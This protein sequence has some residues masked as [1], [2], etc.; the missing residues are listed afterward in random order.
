MGNICVEGA[1][2]PVVT[3]QKKIDGESVAEVKEIKIGKATV[4]K[5]KLADFLAYLLIK[6]ESKV[7]EQL[8]NDFFN[9]L[10]A[11]VCKESHNP[12]ALTDEQIAAINTT[13]NSFFSKIKKRGENHQSEIDVYL[14][15]SQET[16][17]TASSPCTLRIKTPFGVAA[18]V[19]ISEDII[20][21]FNI[22]KNS[23][24]ST[25]GYNGTSHFSDTPST[26]K[27]KYT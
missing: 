1:K 13:V 4:S 10:K 18:E 5:E 15:K 14:E 6:N 3:E 26:T 20:K 9:L 23:S 8:V 2:G 24:T 25:V 7:K 11:E 19:E 21:R 12:C 22:E 17:N 16:S 27:N